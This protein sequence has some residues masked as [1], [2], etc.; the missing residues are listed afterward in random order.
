VLLPFA[1][2]EASVNAEGLKVFYGVFGWPRQRLALERM[3]R[4]ESIELMPLS[5]GGWGYRGSLTL[6]GR[7]ALVVRA[8]P[9]L[10]LELT[11]GKRFVVTVDDAETASK[12]LNGL[13]ERG[14]AG[15]ARAEV[16]SSSAV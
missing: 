16:A 15:N 10:S 3:V 9:A 4:A 1:R 8:G 6:F 5:H 7:A 13:L 12:L 2:I 14:R 11:A